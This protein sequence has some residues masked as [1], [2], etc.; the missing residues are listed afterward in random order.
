M[1]K[2]L[3]II[4]FISAFVVGCSS[5]E[6][7]N[8]TAKKEDKPY[9]RKITQE[10]QNFIQLVLNKDYDN[11][12][13]QTQ[14]QTNEVQKDYNNIA[15]AFKKFQEA[16]DLEKN[17]NNLS[18]QTNEIELKYSTV[19][20][21]LE[22]VKYIPKEIKK[23]VDE[24]SKTSSE[25]DKYYSQILD[26]QVEQEQKDIEKQQF[27]EKVSNRTENPQSVSIGMTKDEVL[28]N[29]WGNPQKINKTT[30]ASGTSEQWVYSG[31]RYLYFEDGILVTI[32]D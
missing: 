20:R 28:S 27:D 26:K 8:A 6:V 5:N 29:G 17:G 12:E 9:T 24:V 2:S 3:L 25:K 7:H 18:Y 4:A 31:Y 10:E 21:S 16:Q 19:L 13:T 15:F 14:G 11:L 23:Q 22:E 32:Q 1:K 30:T